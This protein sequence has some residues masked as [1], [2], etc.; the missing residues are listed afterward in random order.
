MSKTAIAI[1]IAIFG[2]LIPSPAAQAQVV[3]TTLADQDFEDTPATP[4]WTYT[5]TPN[6]L[7]SGFSSAAATPA[8][9]P[10]GIGGSQAWHVVSVS[11]GNPLVFSNQSI[12]PGFDRVVA[13]F[14]LAAMNLISS[15][16]GPDHLDY[17]L[18]EYS[19]DDGAT[20]VARLRVRGALNNNSTWAYDATG[21][22]SVPHLPATEQVFQPTTSGPQ[23]EFGYSTVEIVFP[24]TIIQLALRITP[25]S[26]SSTDS[27]LIDDLELVGEQDVPVELMSFEVS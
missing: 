1:G 2:L 25:R 15:G 22:A 7:V 5:G 9:S 3:T 27:W 20:F 21:V 18:V 12:P 24:G 26:S 10:L 11:G 13:R 14:R 6:A 19:L 8:S 17:V 4:T 16:G 23:T